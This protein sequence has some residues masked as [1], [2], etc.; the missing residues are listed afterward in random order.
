M[1]TVFIGAVEGSAVALR[2]IRE[3]GLPPALVV[4]L[5]LDRS[6]AHSD[7][8]DLEPLAEDC[9]AALLR[10]A[11]SDD[12]ALL[13]ALRESSPD[14][15]MVIGWSQLV[16]PELCAI[17]RLGVLGFHPAP[18]PRMRGRAVIPWQILARQ[19]EGGA[20]LF[21]IGEGIDDGPIAAQALFPIDPDRVTAR[22][23]YDRAVAEMAAL[24]PPLLADLAAGNRPATPQDH[25][26]ATVCARRRPEDGCIDWHR[27]AAEIELLI[28]AVGDPYPGATTTLPGGQPVA[29]NRAR[30]DGRKGY[31]IGLPGQVQE[32]T[33]ETVTVMCGDGACVDLLDWTTE[34]RITRH[35]MLGKR[36]VA[37]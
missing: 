37:G 36:H 18:L 15:I 17:P 21:W 26:R 19:R 8:F 3:A 35:A 16:G 10:T 11:R 29:V 28:R 13:A 20:T 2:A 1:R 5:P 14:L 31:F 7:F 4:T 34:G 23:L 12:P 32:I 33:E 30:L 27:P 22:T 6:G 9:G 25:G 24:L